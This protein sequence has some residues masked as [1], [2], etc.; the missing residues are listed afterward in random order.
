MTGFPLRRRRVLMLPPEEIA[1]NPAQPRRIF[2]EEGLREL[3]ESIRSCGVLQPLT[4]RRQAGKWELIAGERRLRAAQLAGLSA[5][6][7]LPMEVDGQDSALLAL[8]ENLQ[9]RDLHFLEEAAALQAFLHRS[10]MT[11]EQLAEK[12]GRSPSSLANKLRL[13]KLDP[14]CAREVLE[15]GLSER[16]ARALLALSDPAQQLAAARYIRAHQ[17]TV[18]QAERYIAQLPAEKPAPRSRGRYVL[19]DVRLFLNSVDRG[20]QLMQAAGVDAET[21]RQETEDAIVLTIR[22]P[23]QKGKLKTVTG[24]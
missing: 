2:E 6:P 5:V 4:V 12:L 13:L 3:A 17:L 20:L 16:H 19:K 15:G 22:I 8:T 7:C 21:E 1:P 10:G 14:A 11:Q 24:L 18:A 23:R 9:R